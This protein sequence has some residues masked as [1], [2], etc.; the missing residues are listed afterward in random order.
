LNSTLSPDGSTFQF[1]FTNSG[2]NSNASF[3]AWCTTNLSLPLSNW[4]E[5]GPVTNNGPLSYQFSTPALSGSPQL[6]YRV[7]TP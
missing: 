3:T 5:L 1:S 2:Y 7:S 4:T 6:Y